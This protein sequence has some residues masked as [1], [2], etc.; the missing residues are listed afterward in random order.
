VG[1]PN[2]DKGF[3]FFS[4]NIVRNEARMADL[5]IMER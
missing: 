5:V 2:G 3:F 4:N 1:C